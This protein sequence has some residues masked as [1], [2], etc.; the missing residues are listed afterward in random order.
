MGTI[1][2]IKI[3][4]YHTDR[5][6]HVNHAR[7]VEFLEEGRWTY[8][9]EN[10]LMD[11]FHEAGIGH[12][13]ANLNINYRRPA[14]VGDILRVETDIMT[15]NEKSVVML[16]EIFKDE[17]RTVVL[18]ANVTDVFIDAR[19]DEVIPVYDRLLDIWPH[20]R[21]KVLP[22]PGHPG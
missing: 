13:V 19:T 20:L 5:F 9:E 10:R 6:G 16:Q 4:G 8:F 21:E 12:V 22:S 17:G 18:D 14:K 3:R 7:Y 15:V 11:P 1:T 2:E